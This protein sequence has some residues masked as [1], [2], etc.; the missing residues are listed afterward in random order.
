MWG[1]RVTLDCIYECAWVARRLTR[2][3]SLILRQLIAVQLTYNQ[4][5]SSTSS[6]NCC[7]CFTQQKMNIC[8]KL[9]KT[10]LN[11][12]LQPTL[13]WSVNNINNIVQPGQV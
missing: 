4:L 8:S 6:N 5:T 3:T 12:I 2:F 10:G 9:L 11:V 13:F 1:Y 7:F